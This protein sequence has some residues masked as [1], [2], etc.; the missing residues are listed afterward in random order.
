VTEKLSFV[1]KK[2]CKSNETM[3]DLMVALD[4]NAKQIPNV[5]LANTIYV[6]EQ[7]KKKQGSADELLQ[8]ILDEIKGDEMADLYVEVVEKFGISKDDELLSGMIARNKAVAEELE[9]KIADAALNAGDTEV[10]LG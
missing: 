2:N 6:A 9:T 8:K 5:D 1:F 3:A 7:K 10:R 4:E